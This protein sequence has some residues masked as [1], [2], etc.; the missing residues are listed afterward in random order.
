MYDDDLNSYNVDPVHD[1]EIDY[2]FHIKT[3]ALSDE[4]S[5]ESNKVELILP[6]ISSV[7]NGISIGDSNGDS[8]GAYASSKI[9]SD[10]F[11]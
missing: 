11:R 6:I 8:N 7:E 5:L 9:L 3:G 2:D 4:F 1:M 10:F